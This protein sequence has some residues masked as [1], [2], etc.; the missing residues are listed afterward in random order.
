MNCGLLDSGG[1]K[2]NH[3]KKTDTVTG[4]G[5]TL[6]SVETSINVIPLIDFVEKEELSPSVVDETVAKEKQR[7]L[8]NTTGLGSF[9]PHSQEYLSTG[10]AIFRSDVGWKDNI[11]AAMPKIAEEGYYT[12]NIFVE[13]VWKRPRCACCKGI[14]TFGRQDANSSSSTFW[15]AESSSPSTTTPIIEKINNMKNLIIDGK[16]ILV[17]N[18]ENLYST[19]IEGSRELDDYEYD[20]YD[21]D[22]YEDQEIPEMLQAFCD[23]LDKLEI[24]SKEERCNTTLRLGIGVDVKREKKLKQK[25]MGF[26]LD[27]A[28]PVHPKVKV[29]N[30]GDCT[31]R[32]DSSNLDVYHDNSDGSRKKLK[33]TTEQITLLEDRFKIQSTL[34]TVGYNHARGS[35]WMK[36]RVGQGEAGEDGGLIGC[37]IILVAGAVGSSD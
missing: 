4:I 25:T 3:K 16:A 20:P 26:R 31:K 32:S 22:L 11:V 29:T 37:L 13:Y 2:S 17:D 28:L 12:R 9:P 23:R 19:A 14:Y 18:E 7:S 33:L 8:V 30:H 10:N 24:M 35:G 21:D 36:R 34:N 15:N 6:E 27:L 5:L 1:R